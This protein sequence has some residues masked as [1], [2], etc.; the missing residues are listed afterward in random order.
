[1]VRITTLQC[2]KMARATRLATRI[3]QTD[4]IYTPRKYII[5]SKCNSLC[6]KKQI[7][8]QMMIVHIRTRNSS[9]CSCSTNNCFCCSRNTF[10][11]VTSRVFSSSMLRFSTGFPL[12]GAIRDEEGLVTSPNIKKKTR[13]GWWKL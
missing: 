12:A 13:I 6:I 11:A 9:I 2:N 3:R 7:Q 4:S 10:L 1:M 5:Q 8:W